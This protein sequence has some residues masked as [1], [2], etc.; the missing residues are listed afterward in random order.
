MSR[1]IDF[2]EYKNITKDAWMVR[3]YMWLRN[4]GY[5]YE[6][7]FPLGEKKH[8]DIYYD[9]YDYMWKGILPTGERIQGD[10]RSIVSRFVEKDICFR[11][12]VDEREKKAS[13]FEKVIQEVIDSPDSFSIEPF[14]EDCSKQ[15][16]DYLYRLV[17]KV[18]TSREV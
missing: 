13:L 18:K 16:I 15:E 10:L 6:S 3:K 14:L 9:E 17:K 2:S 12:M 5:L 7:L 4:S 11:Y 1:K 8:T